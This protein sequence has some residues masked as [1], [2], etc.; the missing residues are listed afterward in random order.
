[1]KKKA[2]L[3]P[4]TPAKRGRK[5]GSGT[6]YIPGDRERGLVEGMSAYGETAPN[7]AS[8]LRISIATL[9]KFYRKELD[10]AAIQANAKVAANLY[11][12]ATSTTHKNAA[13]SAMFWM[14]TRAHWREK[15][16]LD[17]NFPQF[18]QIDAKDRKL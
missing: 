10:V 6:K 16:E 13:A 3:P 1:V 7:I 4:P 2:P 12:M 5:P 18:V 9:T 11:R 8:V 15:S 14:K 17:V